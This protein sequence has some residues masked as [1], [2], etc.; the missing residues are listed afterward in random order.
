M[1]NK[2][3]TIFLIVFLSVI[4]LCI[5][6]IF[7]F[8]LTNKSFSLFN[9]KSYLLS[10]NLII[11]KS[12][13]EEFDEININSKASEIEI[14]NS[15]SN[16]IRVVV[17]GNDDKVSLENYE[18]KLDI[19]LNNKP[20]KGF[21]INNKIYKIEVYI[22]SN[23]DKKLNISND[24]GDI[25]IGEFNNLSASIKELAG[26]I[27]IKSLD[28]ADISNN[29]GDIKISKKAKKLDIL[30]KSGDVEINEVNIVK[31]I[32]N[33][34]D[35]EINKVNSFL[36]I[37]NNCGDIEINSIT[38]EENSKIK[39]DLGDIEIGKTNEIF[40]NAKTSLGDTKINKNY[41]SDITL[42]INNSCGDIEINN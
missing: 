41:K 15:D 22:P 16:N 40:I 9:N 11:D 34:G 3:L 19:T 2:G 17:Y 39:N 6:G 20:C 26:D 27:D 29:Y 25:K 31:V 28:N 1:K 12:F 33:Y 4:T 23:Y 5:T 10:S 24:Y 8:I 42:D 14:I 35:I 36:D 7:V 21:C 32:N 38:L 13:D 18:K 30:E 37:E